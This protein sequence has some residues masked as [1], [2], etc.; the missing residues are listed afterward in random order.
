M[1]QK[2]TTGINTCDA[3]GILFVGLKLTD[4]IDW[5]WLWVVSPWLIQFVLILICAYIS[6]K[7]K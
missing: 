4:Y 2:Y 7:R 3:L 5:N 1:K 6:D